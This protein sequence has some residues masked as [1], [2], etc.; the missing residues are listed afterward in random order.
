[1]YT[2]ENLSSYDECEST[3]TERAQFMCEN[4]QLKKK[5]KNPRWLLTYDKCV[6][7]VPDL[8]NEECRWLWLCVCVYM[9][10]IGQDI[11]QFPQRHFSCMC[12][13]IHKSV[14]LQKGEA[15]PAS[16]RFD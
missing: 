9:Y 8:H 14:M 1:M 4:K 13:H 16:L 12:T 7:Y 5:K 11:T 10:D 3:Q 6:S 15:V 2:L